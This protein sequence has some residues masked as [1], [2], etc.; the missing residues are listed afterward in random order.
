[1]YIYIYVSFCIYIYVYVYLCINTVYTRVCVFSVQ[2]PVIRNTRKH[3]TTLQIR[4]KKGNQ[5]PFPVRFDFVYFFKGLQL[6]IPSQTDGSTPQPAITQT[7]LSA[8]L[9]CV[10]CICAH[11]SGSTGKWDWM[12]LQIKYDKVIS[13]VCSISLCI[14]IGIRIWT[15]ICSM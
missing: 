5:W 13:Y 9:A 14:G 11:S 3:S 7:R 15:C 2:T 12:W 4:F 10:G 8:I 6:P 1:M